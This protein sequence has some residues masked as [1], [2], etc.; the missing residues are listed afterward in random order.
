MSADGVEIAAK[1]VAVL[2]ARVFGNGQ[3]SGRGLQ[4]EGVHGEDVV[5]QWHRGRDPPRRCG[6][7]ARHAGEMPDSV[8]DSV[9]R[10]STLPTTSSEHS[11]IESTHSRSYKNV[12]KDLI[13]ADPRLKH[14]LHIQVGAAAATSSASLSNHHLSSIVQRGQQGEQFSRQHACLRFE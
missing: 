14:P 11:L 6:C 10:Q 8:P 2:D 7:R 5:R 1:C 9:P 3:S 12:L 4:K 13:Q